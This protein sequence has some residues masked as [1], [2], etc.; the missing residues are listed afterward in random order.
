MCPVAVLCNFIVAK[1]RRDGER[2][3]KETRE[4]VS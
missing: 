2:V 4:G 3:K 1:V